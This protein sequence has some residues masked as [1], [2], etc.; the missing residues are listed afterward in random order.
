MKNVSMGGLETQLKVNQQI[1][2]ENNKDNLIL[3]YKTYK[4]CT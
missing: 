1:H 4:P 2:K 3:L